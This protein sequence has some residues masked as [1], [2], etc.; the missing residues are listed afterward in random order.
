MDQPTGSVTSLRIYCYVVETLSV[1][2]RLVL[3]KEA[4]HSC[5]LGRRSLVH[6]MQKEEGE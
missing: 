3:K 5:V 2:A 4:G 6:F 1:C